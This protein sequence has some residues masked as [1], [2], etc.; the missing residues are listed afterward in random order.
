M[1]VPRPAHRWFATAVTVVTAVLVAGATAACG[2]EA[3]RSRATD[4]APASPAAQDSPA[5]TAATGAT[6][7]TGDQPGPDRVPAGFPLAAGLPERNDDGSPVVV[8]EPAGATR[9]RLCP[10][11]AWSAPAARAAATVDYAAPEDVRTRTLLVLDTVALAQRA[12]ADLRGAISR[13]AEDDRPD[14]TVWATVED[15]A[16]APTPGREWLVATQR[17]RTDGL[18]DTGLT[19]LRVARYGRALV[20]SSE[21]GEGGGSA[22]SIE[23]AIARAAD[24]L[25]E[26]ERAA[27][28]AWL[29]ADS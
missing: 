22:A 18:F 15:D 24:D 23:A 11:E 27:S 5:A 29:P 20:V 17:Y 26:V 4:P 19:V 7:A 2:P 8:G 6:G 1:S 13:C 25:A 14:G 12:T 3:A 9:L 21:Y 28:T 16:A 10:E